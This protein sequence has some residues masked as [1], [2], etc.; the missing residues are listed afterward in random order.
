MTKLSRG[1]QQCYLESL[2]TSTKKRLTLEYER[3]LLPFHNKT[4]TPTTDSSAALV[5]ISKDGMN[6]S[7][8]LPTIS[9]EAAKPN[10][11]ANQ[12]SEDTRVPWRRVRRDEEV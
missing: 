4:H 11:H 6:S 8:D 5:G 3:Q 10:I 7:T 9:L 1:L 2:Y 12:G